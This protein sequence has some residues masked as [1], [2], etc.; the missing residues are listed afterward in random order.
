MPR[1]AKG[2]HAHSFRVKTRGRGIALGVALGLAACVPAQDTA[3]KPGGSPP[4]A[5][6]TPGAAGEAHPV[7]LAPNLTGAPAPAPVTA[8][9]PI[10]ARPLPPP[11]APA[12][13]PPAGPVV[14]AHPAPPPPSPSPSPPPPPVPAAAPHPVAVPPAVAAPAPPVAAAAAVPPRAEP[15]GKP[16][17]PGTYGVWSPPDVI[18]QSVFVCRTQAGPP[19]R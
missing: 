10:A 3:T 17:P 6:A 2:P 16:C 19:P 8:A 4:S 7:A 5:A 12:A 15:P 1:N 11:P 9:A 14:A 18:G 13:A